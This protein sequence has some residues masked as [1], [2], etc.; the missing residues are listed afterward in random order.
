MMIA[1]RIQGRSSPWQRLYNP[2][3]TCAKDFHGESH[4]IVGRADDT[5]PGEGG[6]ILEGNKRISVHWDI[7]GSFT[8]FPQPA[9]TR[10]AR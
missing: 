2:T 9:H 7:E 10:A 1:D 4:S 3:R 8:L 5:P 6:V